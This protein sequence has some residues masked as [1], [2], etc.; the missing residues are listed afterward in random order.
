MNPE[1][2]NTKSKRLIKNSLYL[3]IRMFLILIL[4]LYTSRV[5]LDALGV[6]DFGIYNVVGGIVLMFNIICGSFS[7]STSRFFAYEIGKGNEDEVVSLFF[8]SRTVQLLLCCLVIVFAEIAGLYLIDNKLIIPEDRLFAAKVILHLS[9]ITF[10][11]K[12]MCI[13]YRALIIAKEKM[14][15]YAVAGLAEAFM[16]LII[17]L[18]LQQC[19]RDRLIY[20]GWL[21]MLE[22]LVLIILFSIYSKYKISKEF[23]FWKLEWQKAQIKRMAS[24]AGWDS[25]GA[26]ERIMLDQGINLLIN[27][28]FNPAI[29]AAR[30]VAFQVRHAVAQFSGNFQIATAPQITKSYA[31]HDYQYM[32]SVI[33]K[34][35][36]YSF[37]VLL[38]PIVPLIAFSEFWL[39]IWLKEVPVHAI[40]F[41]NLSLI[42]ILVDS[43]YEILNQGAKATGRIKW[44][45]IITCMVSLLNFPISYIAL[46]NGAEPESTMYICIGVGIA[47]LISQLVIL[48]KMIDLHVMEFLKE[49]TARCY[50]IGILII[51][52]VFFER[53]FNLQL[54]PI[55]IFLMS[56]VHIIATMALIWIVGLDKSKS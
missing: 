6:E 33:N 20:Y 49:V 35:C 52:F 34:A 36:K 7:E 48:H 55:E 16:R 45:R 2:S 14:G 27:T 25:L 18:L 10:A 50:T 30:G 9:I 53:K 22:P 31:E 3:Y 13:P 21:L 39:S 37:Y 43:T 12:L 23:T 8:N 56:I 32:F 5:I 42:F 38:I 41:V 44:F 15:F 51:T 46:Y 29:N 40:A 24:F 47:V 26:L 17:A 11:I 54:S 1:S 28:F 4:S 19:D